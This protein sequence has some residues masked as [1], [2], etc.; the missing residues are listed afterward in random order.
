MFY[1][2]HVFI[3]TNQK[4]IGK[5]CCQNAQA[6]DKAEYMKAQLKEKQLF[7]PGAV[8]VSTAK[9]LGRCSVGPSMVIYPAGIWYTYQSESDINRIIDEYLVNNQTIRDLEIPTMA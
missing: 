8:R 1:K 4:E 5:K 2:H 9:C 3:C 6:S 7:G